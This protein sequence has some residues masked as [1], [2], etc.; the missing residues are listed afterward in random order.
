MIRLSESITSLKGVGPKKSSLLHRLDIFTLEDAL[1]HFPRDYE[2]I[3]AVKPIEAVADGEMA[4]VCAV[5]ADSSR[6]KRTKDLVVTYVKACDDTGQAECVWF[7]QPYRASLYKPDVPYFIRGKAV[8]KGKS[9]QL[10]NPSIEAFDPKIHKLDRL[11]PV[12]PLTRGLTQNDLRNLVHG[13]LSSVESGYSDPFDKLAV[14]EYGLISKA[15]AYK[16]IHFPDSINS[17]HMARKR[18]IFDEFFAMLVSIGYQRKVIRSGFIGKR[19]SADHSLVADFLNG[20]P[21]KLTVS[22]QKALADIFADLSGGK[23][24]N[25]LIQ[26][27]VGSGKTVIA[28]A[29]MCAA[30]ASGHQSAMMVPTEILA[31]QHMRTMSRMFDK[32]DIR[33]SLL[34]GRMSNADKALVKRSIAEGTTNIVIGTHAILQRDV[35]FKDL[36]LVITD[37]QHRFGVMQRMLLRSKSENT[38]PHFLVMSATPIPRTLAQIMHGDLDVSILDGKPPGRV[39]VKTHLITS[40]LRD[41]LYNFIRNRALAGEQAYIVCQQIENGSDGIKSAE[42]LYAE[43]VKT[44]LKGIETGLIHGRLKPEEKEEIMEA[45]VNGRIRVL[46]ATTVIEVGVNVPNATIIAIENAERF[47]L[48]QLHQLR[49]RVGRGDKPSY[50]IL[51]SD[52]RDE[53]AKDR[54]M[55]LV[56]SNDGFELAEKDLL[57]RGPGDLYGTRQHGLPQ[58]AIAHPLMDKDML[59]CAQ[60]AAKLVLD[61]ADQADY[62]KIIEICLEKYNKLAALPD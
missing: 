1:N 28:A 21:F 61:R 52:A 11:L 53:M 29:A 5:F 54:L 51:I 14:E 2:E 4:S 25:R 22:Q 13:I 34:T 20:L 40:S 23:I 48:A 12:Y 44:H 15:N 58:F 41:R 24:M 45:F 47:G 9:L 62:K 57:L 50:C 32:T 17:V 30:A 35:V 38:M 59:G 36:A 31:R 33:L 3:K 7:N 37:E 18:L 6:K 42:E 27:D 8:R 55:A 56:K 60:G 46:V 19:I 43:L 39:P 26:G 49:G 10:Q 16:L